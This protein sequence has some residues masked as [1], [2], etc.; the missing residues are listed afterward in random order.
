MG[1]LWVKRFMSED[2]GVYFRFA[3]TS[4]WIAKQEALFR[5][6]CCHGLRNVCFVLFSW[7]DC[8]N[9]QHQ[10]SRG[11]KAHMHINLGWDH[12]GQPSGT[13]QFNQRGL[14][15]NFYEL[16]SRPEASRH[17]EAAGPKL[18]LYS[19]LMQASSTNTLP[20]SDFAF[21]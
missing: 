13:T 4:V 8:C 11:I 16:S 2:M 12:A 3:S 7:L 14:S 20:Q 21:S 18:L 10:G 19:R 9:V 5:R 1:S 15:V 6:G 17:N